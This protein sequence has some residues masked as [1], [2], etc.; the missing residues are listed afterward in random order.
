MIDLIK[1]AHIMPPY[2]RNKVYKGPVKAVILDW[3]GT[4]VDYGCIGP[5]AVFIEV[6]KKFDIEVSVTEARQ[7]MGLMKKDHIRAMCGLPRVIEQWIG[8]YGSEPSEEDINR[9]YAETEPMMTAVIDQ[10]AVPIPGLLKAVDA[11]RSRGIK[12]GSSTGYTR[13]MVDRLQP[14]AAQKGYSPDSVVCSSDVPAG[15]PYPWMALL[16]AI[17]LEVYPMEAIVKIGD[18]LTDIA[19]GLNAGMWTIGLTQS[20]NELGLS[21]EEAHQLDPAD[22]E[23]RLKD[24]K[25]RF[26]DSGAHYVARGIWDCVPLIDDI[27]TK[28]GRG[29]QP[30]SPI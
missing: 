14:A 30:L 22:L 15:R 12:I 26:L 6:F 10:Y 16:N 19:E 29:E 23:K 18:T 2:L 8:R 21:E 1:G 4:A 25:Q 20:G 24:I 7:F 5:A 9:L 28:L 11:F 3:A 17:K 13:P 27:E